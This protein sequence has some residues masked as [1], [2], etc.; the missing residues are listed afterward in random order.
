[1]KIIVTF[2]SKHLEWLHHKLNPMYVALVV[3]A[4]NENQ[5]RLEV[6]NSRIGEHFSTSYPY[7][8]HIEEFKS[9]GMKEYTLE[10]LEAKKYHYICKDKEGGLFMTT[11]RCINTEDAKQYIGDNEV[12]Y[13]FIED[14][15]YQILK[16]NKM[17]KEQW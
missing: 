6:F 3:E 7:D 2:G 9:K 10:E 4:E 11:E 14:D 1:M 13:P 8:N 15:Y 12:L 5:A 17:R 16:R